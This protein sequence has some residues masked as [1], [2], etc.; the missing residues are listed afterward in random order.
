MRR[1]LPIFFI[2]F[3]GLS[4]G[5][6]TYFVSQFGAGNQNGSSWLNAF[7]NL[8]DA[9]TKA[10]AGDAIWVAQ[11]YYYP[12]N[13]SDRGKTFVL[14]SG[15]KIYGGFQGTETLLTQR[16]FEQYPVI[17]SGDIGNMDDTTDNSNNIM[18]MPHPSAE[19]LVDGFVF[20][21]GYAKPDTLAAVSALGRAGS[22]IYI[23]ADSTSLPQFRNCQFLDNYA[24]GGGG[25]IYFSAGANGGGTPIFYNC[26]FINNKSGYQGGA[27]NWTG[28]SEIDPG[29]EFDHCLFDNNYSLGF[30]GSIA[31]Y[32]IAGKNEIEFSN[33]T[34]KNISAK[35]QFGKFME[36]VYRDGTV[37]SLKLSFLGSKIGL[38]TNLSAELIHIQPENGTLSD[39]GSFSIKLDGNQ[40]YRISGFCLVDYTPNWFENITTKN[41]FESSGLSY[42]FGYISGYVLNGIFVAHDNLS[43]D[44]GAFVFGDTT[45]TSIVSN[46]KFLYNNKITG[47]YIYNRGKIN[48]LVFNNNI[49]AALSDTTT[50]ILRNVFSSKSTALLN[51]NLFYNFKFKKPSS[52]LPNFQNT[53]L[54]KNNIFYKN[55]NEDG[56]P[57][58]LHS[59]TRDSFILLNNLMDV[60]CADLPVGFNC[61]QGNIFNANPDF[62]D[63]IAGDFSLLPCSPAIDAGDTTAISQWLSQHD[64]LGNPRLVNGKID[65]GPI[66]SSAVQL[67]PGSAIVTP[68]CPGGTA[69]AVQFLPLNACPPFTFNWQNG[70]T[71]GQGTIDLAPGEYVFTLTDSRNHSATDTVTIP[72]T[73]P[74]Q[75]VTSTQ[76]IIC[77]DTL[78][79]SA[80]LEGQGNPPFTFLWPDGSDSS[81][82][83]NLPP[84]E[85]A[86]LLTDAKGCTATGTVNIE[87]TG[88]L[89]VQISAEEIT[90]FDAADGQLTVLPENGKAPFHWIWNPASG[91]SDSTATISMLPPGNYQGTL[92]DDFGCNISWTLPLEAPD[93]LHLEASVTEATDSLFLD[94]KI[95]ITTISGGK[96]P[97]KI[98]WSNGGNGLIIK[99]LKHG[100]YTA[101]LTDDNGCEKIYIFAVGISTG[102]FEH[103]GIEILKIYPNPASHFV[104]FDVPEN[105]KTG[106]IADFSGKVLG[107][108]NFSNISKTA[109][110]DVSKLPSGGYF[111]VILDG[112]KVVSA[113]K[114][115]IFK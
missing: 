33:C 23:L 63:E 107:R 76:P 92:T 54:F 31:I 16:N 61:G 82:K 77:G 38:K 29:F 48:S 50:F 27:I 86:V 87:K 32:Q 72:A 36:I 103:P 85:Y 83:T 59:E 81:T 67:D 111:L 18:V 79:G 109:Q 10:V 110:L 95:E 75:I 97:Y 6:K 37:D 35:A 17:L 66:E 19:T 24:S 90:C 108:L 15:V 30:G 22:A 3:T 58:I 21:H 91:G 65:I 98:K 88:N 39:I 55:K 74:P 4:F 100:F 68:S 115:K 28:G 46:N 99:D 7:K 47:L 96:M 42:S 51:N 56:S 102:I 113:G 20:R 52:N 44:G 1:F 14:K 69:G 43:L 12:D 78:G 60:G 5:Q 49:F 84:G 71:T 57:T 112:E 2:L 9:L 105:A 101:T 8:H 70:A 89:S 62:V 114:F 93:S 45:F 73:A 40:F 26:Q 41:Y 106:T 13:A 104:K 34:I 11:G 53:Y 64:F 80:F 94:G 25:A